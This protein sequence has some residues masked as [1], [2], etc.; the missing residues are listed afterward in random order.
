MSKM[1]DVYTKE[2]TCEIILFM[3]NKILTIQC[4]GEK[5]YP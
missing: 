2:R 4:D 1:M 5:K 3:V